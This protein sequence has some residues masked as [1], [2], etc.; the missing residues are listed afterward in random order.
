MHF[1]ADIYSFLKQ[2]I[3][4]LLT[5]VWN[6]KLPEL[7][8]SPFF[9]FYNYYTLPILAWF[10]VMFAQVWC[11]VIFYLSENIFSPVQT[12]VQHT[13]YSV[14]CET[15]SKFIRKILE[16]CICKNENLFSFSKMLIQVKQESKFYITFI[17]YHYQYMYSQDYTISNGTHCINI[18][19]L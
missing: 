13:F 4:I 14:N 18:E 1:N 8:Y 17:V 5:M 11:E 2:H 10:W 15:Q 19:T 9:A 6:L 7:F 3:Y 16:S 12:N